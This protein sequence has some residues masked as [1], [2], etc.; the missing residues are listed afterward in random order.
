MKSLRIL[1]FLFCATVCACTLDEDRSIRSESD[2]LA[3]ITLIR[4][5]F[6]D[7]VRQ[8]NP[9]SILATLDESIVVMYPNKVPIIGL[10]EFRI[11][12]EAA[13]IKPKPDATYET[14]EVHVSDDWAIERGSTWEGTFKRL[15]IYRRQPDGGWR[16]SHI[17]WSSNSP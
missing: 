12:L 11:W 3:A 1:S 5:Q 6:T 4:E 9:D 8:G 17:L 16:I 10:E 15:W 14:A 2:D 7:G 13:S